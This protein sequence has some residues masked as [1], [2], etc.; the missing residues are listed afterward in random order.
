MYYLVPLCLRDKIQPKKLQQYPK[1]SDIL[2]LRNFCRGDVLILDQGNGHNIFQIVRLS[3]Q[4]TMC[5]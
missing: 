4:Y 3:L 2:F 1:K 5:F